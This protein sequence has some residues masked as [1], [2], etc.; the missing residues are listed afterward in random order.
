MH[1]GVQNKVQQK[2]KNKKIVQ[3]HCSKPNI[4]TVVR[5]AHSESWYN[6][7]LN[8]RQEYTVH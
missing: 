5:C 6:I 7:T 8:L 4:Q 1:V 2:V 3:I